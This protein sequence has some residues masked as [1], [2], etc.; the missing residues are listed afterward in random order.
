MSSGGAAWAASRSAAGCV[1]CFRSPRGRAGER[2]GC[3]CIARSLARTLL[4]PPGLYE[5]GRHDAMRRHAD[6]RRAAPCRA[7][8]VFGLAT[9]TLSDLAFSRRRASRGQDM[10]SVECEGSPCK[11]RLAWLAGFLV[12]TCSTPCPG[13]SVACL[14]WCA[15]RVGVVL[16]V[17]H[18]RQCRHRRQRHGADRP[19]RGTEGGDSKGAEKGKRCLRRGGV[20]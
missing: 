9:S 16:C 7:V 17:P 14:N 2:V 12:L 3:T 5:D 6:A 10:H 4:A 8:L 15:A 13:R 20:G 19:R 1:Y 18:R 11:H